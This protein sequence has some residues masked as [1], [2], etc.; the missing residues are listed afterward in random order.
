MNINFTPNA[1]LD[2]QVLIQ[3]HQLPACDWQSRAA[4]AECALL[5]AQNAMRCAAD[6]LQVNAPGKALEVLEA[7]LR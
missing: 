4:A 3:H 7:N 5:E 6:L 2:G 1:T